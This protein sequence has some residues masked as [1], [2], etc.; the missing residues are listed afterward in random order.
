M[1]QEIA[2]SAQQSVV[3]D[4]GDRLVRIDMGR[5]VGTDQLWPFL[6]DRRSSEAEATAGHKH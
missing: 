5:K 2:I 1:V 3:A 6:G 4:M